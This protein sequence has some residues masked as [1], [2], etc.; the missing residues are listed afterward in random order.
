M[1]SSNIKNMIT[2]DI[3]DAVCKAFLRYRQTGNREDYLEM[4]ELHNS[5]L[6]VTGRDL[7]GSV[8]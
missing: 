2:E 3:S 8:D 1:G 7:V 4:C 6:R 5:W